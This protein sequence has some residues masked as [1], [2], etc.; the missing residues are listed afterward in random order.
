MVVGGGYWRYVTERSVKGVSVNS[1]NG[2]VNS[3][4][5]VDMRRQK[6]EHPTHL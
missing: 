2:G 3:V 4:D 1:V 5:I 6:N